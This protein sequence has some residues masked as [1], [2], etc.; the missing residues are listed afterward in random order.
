[1]AE[2]NFNKSS[3][4]L[5]IKGDIGFSDVMA[6]QQAGEQRIMAHP[7]CEIDLKHIGVCNI[8]CIAML[9]SWKRLARRQKQTLTYIQTP[10]LIEHLARVHGVY[11]LLFE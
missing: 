8:A 7:N 3:N 11:A 10:T 2:I 1:M 9:V 6:L 5:E 4:K